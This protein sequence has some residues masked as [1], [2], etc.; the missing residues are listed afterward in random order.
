M[1]QDRN[2]T[3]GLGT[4]LDRWHNSLNLLITSTFGSW[5]HQICIQKL[6]I[7]KLGPIQLAIPNHISAQCILTL[8]SVATSKLTKILTGSSIYKR[9]ISQCMYMME[10]VL[11][12]GWHM[13]TLSPITRSIPPDSR[14]V[15]SWASSDSCVVRRLLCQTAW[16]PPLTN[17]HCAGHPKEIYIYVQ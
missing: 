9:L 10:P 17:A 11:T 5:S 7:I 4:R 6:L 14:H 2:F 1:H 12:S 15:Q 3:H 16:L 8:G 13:Y